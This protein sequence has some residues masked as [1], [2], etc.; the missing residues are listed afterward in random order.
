MDLIKNKSD[1]SK[2]QVIDWFKSVLKGKINY[3]GEV[4]GKNNKVFLKYATELNKI[5]NE[6]I[7][8]LNSQMELLEKI[9]K[10]VFVIEHDGNGSYCQ[11][12]GF[13]L[14][15]VGLLTNYHVTEENEIYNVFTCKSEKVTSLIN[16]GNLLA[17]NREIDYACYN[18]GGQSEDALLLGNSKNLKIGDKVIIIGYPN[19][20]VGNSPEI[21]SVDIISVR[22][23]MKQDIYTVSGR[24]VHGA[25]GG[26]VLNLSYEVVGVIRCGMA[27]TEELDSNANQ[28][29]IPIHDIVDDLKKQKA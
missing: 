5:C 17:C 25:S 7:I 12:S 28:G 6:E 27:T 1:E 16:P 10:S 4:N 2:E 8:H 24:V 9:E 19:Y 15:N 20:C 29:F 13:I 21:Q 14:K 26:V 22:K 3:I 23:F 18:W 11:G